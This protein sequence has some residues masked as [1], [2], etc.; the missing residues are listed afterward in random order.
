MISINIILD[1]LAMYVWVVTNFRK[2]KRRVWWLPWAVG[3]RIRFDACTDLAVPAAFG[4]QCCTSQQR[5]T[6]DSHPDSTQ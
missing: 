4:T 2:I 1:F 3:E 5:A 6:S